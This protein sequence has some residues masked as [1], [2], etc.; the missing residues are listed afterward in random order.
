[1]EKNR[2]DVHILIYFFFF[3]KAF[4]LDQLQNRF[5]PMEV[6]LETKIQIV[7]PLVEYLRYY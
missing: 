3:F 7:N 4:Q 1:M 2:V 5:P 6:Y